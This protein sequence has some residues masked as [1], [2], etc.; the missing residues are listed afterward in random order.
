MHS[1]LLRNTVNLL[2]SSR[3]FLSLWTHTLS[4]FNVMLQVS[5]VSLKFFSVLDHL[6][7][8][9]DDVLHISH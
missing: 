1:V 4:N 2:L 8:T 6:F 9:F 5:L 3:V 7:G